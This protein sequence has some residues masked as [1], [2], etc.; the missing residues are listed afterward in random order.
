MGV[1]GPLVTDAGCSWSCDVG[2]FEIVK[3]CY[4]D[5]SRAVELVIDSIKNVYEDKA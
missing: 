1:R 4:S 5:V 3:S 2:C